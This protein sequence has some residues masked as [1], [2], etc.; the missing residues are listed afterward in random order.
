MENTEEKLL[1][2]TKILGSKIKINN[3]E[4]TCNIVLY[5]YNAQTFL[6][7]QSWP[8]EKTSYGYEENSCEKVEITYIKIMKILII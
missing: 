4:V 5:I 1:C 2:I 6:H 8:N 3:Q 7:R